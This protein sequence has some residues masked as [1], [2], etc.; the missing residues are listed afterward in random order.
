MM[1]NYEGFIDAARKWVKDTYGINEDNRILQSLWTALALEIQVKPLYILNKDD[2]RKAFEDMDEDI[3]ELEGNPVFW[4]RVQQS[5]EA[6]MA[7]LWRDIVV[8]A[9][10]KARAEIPVEEGGTCEGKVRCPECGLTFDVH[11]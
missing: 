11:N 8:E 1:M 6:A 3:G 4:N 10:D 9:I 5:I 7:E 2:V